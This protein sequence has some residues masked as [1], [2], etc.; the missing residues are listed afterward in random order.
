MEQINY[1]Q[2]AIEEKPFADRLAYFIKHVIRPRIVLDIGCGPGH[3]VESM[4]D[5]DINSIGIDIDQRI[6]DKPYLFQQDILSTK[7]VADTCICLEVVEHIDEIHADDVVDAIYGMFL[8]TL[9][10]TAAQ[11]GQSGVGHINCQYR[12]YW[13]KKFTDLGCVRNTLMED[14][15]RY[16]CKQGRYMGWFYNNVMVFNKK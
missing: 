1:T 12:E 7:F 10:F 14:L 8:D 3:F 16:Y 5:L 11:P 6:G 9:I 4:R 13:S 2:I 15:L